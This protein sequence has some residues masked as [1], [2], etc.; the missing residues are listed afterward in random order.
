MVEVDRSDNIEESILKSLS[1]IKLSNSFIKDT[2]EEKDENWIN[3]GEYG[4]LS[5]R[6][7]Q[8]LL[9]TNELSIVSEGSLAAY[10]NDL[11][12]FSDR[13]TSTDHV[14]NSIH[15][16]IRVLDSIGD[17]EA[18]NCL[19][20]KIQIDQSKHNHKIV[21]P[22]H[23]IHAYCSHTDHLSI[24]HGYYANSCAYIAANKEMD[25]F[26]ALLQSYSSDN[27]Y[28]IADYSIHRY[29]THEEKIKLSSLVIIYSVIYLDENK[30][31]IPKRIASA[32]ASKSSVIDDLIKMSAIS[33]AG[34]P[35]SDFIPSFN[36]LE[37]ATKNDQTIAIY[38]DDFQNI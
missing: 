37:E 16:S 38:F 2:I 23:I 7:L 15:V 25:H 21:S 6:S 34:I 36:S 32:S 11:L 12:E 4:D 24:V 30:R 22:A 26:Y 9:E 1:S 29:S 3:S 10:T 17:K 28:I 18:T 8:I 35:V 14:A 13:P 33:S 31:S 5:T 27:E 19:L 20:S